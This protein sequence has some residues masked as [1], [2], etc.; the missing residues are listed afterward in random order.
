MG[1]I[2]GS[3]MTS[4]LQN[5]TNAKKVMSPTGK[6]EFVRRICLDSKIISSIWDVSLK[7]DVKD[8]AGDLGLEFKR[9]R[10]FICIH[11]NKMETGPEK[12]LGV[13][14]HLMFRKLVISRK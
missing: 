6:G 13:N 10:S 9:Y 2:K 8:A 7:G 14:P 11:G 12:C 5:W 4:K 1:K 3:S